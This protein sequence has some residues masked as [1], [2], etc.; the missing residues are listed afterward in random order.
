MSSNKKSFS[1]HRLYHIV[2]T[3]GQCVIAIITSRLEIRREQEFHD[4]CTPHMCITRTADDTSC[5]NDG[6]R[7]SQQRHAKWADKGVLSRLIYISKGYWYHRKNV[8]TLSALFHKKF[9]LSKD[10][11]MHPRWFWEFFLLIFFMIVYTRW[12]TPSVSA[13]NL[14]FIEAFNMKIFEQV[15]VILY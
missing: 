12:R 3:L 7:W 4:R 9:Y 2:I 11:S 13:G 5:G 6:K 14:I 15:F 1:P 10:L 8:E